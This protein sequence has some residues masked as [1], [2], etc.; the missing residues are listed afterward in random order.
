MEEAKRAQEASER[1][2][3]DL[4]VKVAAE[5]KQ[6]EALDETRARLTQ[7]Q[8]AK[9][10]EQQKL[11]SSARARAE[12]E[13]LAL[14]KARAAAE[15]EAKAL[16][17]A[18]VRADAAA[19]KQKLEFEAAQRDLR[20][21]LKAEIEAQVR[22]EMEAMLKTDIEESAREEVEAAVLQGAQEDARR[23]LE[24]RLQQE[25][26]TLERAEAESKARAEIDAKRMLA[27]QEAKIRAEME[28]RIAAISREKEQAENEA[29]RLAEAQSEATAKAVAKAAAE[30]AANLKA[31]EEAR[32]QAEAQA[33]NQRLRLEARAREEATERV[34]VE[35][36]MATKLAAEKEATSEARA[37]I[38]VEKELREKADR[39]NQAQLDA[40]RR[41]REEAEQTAERATKAREEASRAVSEQVAKRER[42]EREAE[43]R[44]LQERALREKAEEKS[45]LEAEAEAQSR[46]AQVLRLRELREQAATAKAD[47]TGDRPARRKPKRDRHLM[48]WTLVSLFVL[49]GLAVGLIQIVPLHSV[50][51][52]LEKSL[53]GWLHDDVTSS[54]L[55]I[56][57]FPR[58][59][60]KLDQ[61]AVGKLLDARASS[62]RI[63]MDL[64]ALFGERLVVDTIE[65]NDVTVSAEAL[66]RA[67]AW[68]DAAGRP[69]LIEI[70]AIVL[71]NIKLDVAGVALD[72][73]DASF[74]F[75]KAGAL[76]DAAMQSAAGKWSLGFVPEKTA[77]LTTPPSESWAVDFAA[78]TIN[79]PIGVEMPIGEIKGKG[80]LIGSELNFPQ[81]D[82]KLFEGTAT[83]SL[84]ADWKQGINVSADINAK[85]IMLD[86]LTAVFTRNIGL[87]GR[88][89]GQ[90]SIAASAPAVGNLLERP[91]VQGS[92]LVKDGAIGNVDLIQAMRSP[93]SGGR[94]G[95]SKFTELAGQLNVADGT[96]R[97]D[98]LKFTGG[99]LLAQGNIAVG[100]DKGLLTGNLSSEIRSNVA[101][102]RATFSLSGNIARPIL[103]RGG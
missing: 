1:A 93:D 20:Q 72:P 84:R 50:N 7:E 4:E 87:S 83:A 29:R 15:A 39:E 26:N 49:L 37:R 58:P 55:H 63:Y 82:M 101:Q 48:R 66:A 43:Q 31:Q 13:A 30:Y 6:R 91:R 79:L 76:I 23:M 69:P 77:G 12:A 28:L 85:K 74:R 88:M 65:L 22:A 53:A 40:E 10:A 3:L 11:L 32:V 61:V 33:K 8:I 96:I 24:E 67:P 46:A 59:H 51:A 86:Q 42:F 89:D 47:E 14:A 70:G 9:E 95:Q 45:R 44:V 99:V 27:E 17:E 16:A 64:K 60:L 19:L 34:R 2:R 25:R 73:F 38:L 80:S 100:V 57:L 98:K 41:A 92:F 54:N 52:R 71:K 21:Q 78:R 97:F 75:N 18:R 35:A 90:F 81:I 36:E 56:S 94:G 62:G 68:S 102:D 103:K 5:K